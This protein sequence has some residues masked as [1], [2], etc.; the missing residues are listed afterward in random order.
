MG[1]TKRRRRRTTNQLGSVAAKYQTSR[2]ALQP[3]NATAEQPVNK[4]CDS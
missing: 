3:D 1:T 4:H 2:V